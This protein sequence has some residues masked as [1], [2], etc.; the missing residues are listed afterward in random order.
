MLLT[1]NNVG[2]IGSILAAVT[3]I[4]FVVIAVVGVNIAMEPFG[5]ALYSTVN[6][7]IGILISVLLRYQGQK[8]AE[9][10]N[11]NL[12]K[13]FYEKK[14]K[15]KKHMSMSLWFTLK[16]I[17][18]I[19]IKGG[20][21]AFCLFGT[22]YITIVGSKNPIQIV[23]TLCTLLLF[24][25]FGLIAMNSAY[26]RFYNVQIPIMEQKIKEKGEQQNGTL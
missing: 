4:I 1:L 26:C 23:I 19:V 11:E 14:V 20:S 17:Q 24:A 16:A 9:V 3:D 21:T 25:C 22:T 2:I 7:L 13:Q 18:D 6:A 10:E 5:V 15:E 8:Y 12:C